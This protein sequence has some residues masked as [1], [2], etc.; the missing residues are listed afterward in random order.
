M[1]SF[2]LALSL[3]A[4]TTDLSTSRQAAGPGTG[5][6]CP[7]IGC[8]SNTSKV[9][10]IP[11]IRAHE[12]GRPNS[13]GF[14]IVRFE[15]PLAA[16]GWKRYHADVVDA[17]LLVRD[18]RTNVIVFSGVHVTGG[19]FVLA[20][21]TTGLEYYLEV[22]A[23]GTQE[24]WA[25]DDPAH[26]VST[27][28]YHL[29]WEVT[30]ATNSEQNLCDANPDGASGG[31]PPMLD[32][33]AVLFDEE[34]VDVDGLRFTG[35]AHDWFNIGCA[36]NALAKVHF[37]GKTHAASNLLG[38]T[39]TVAERTAHLKMMTADYCGSGNAFTVPGVPL[40]WR[41]SHGWVDTIASG[42]T[43]EARWFEGGALCLNEPRIEYQGAMVPLGSTVFPAGIEILLDDPTWCASR[44][45]PCS[46]DH[47]SMGGADVI[48]ANP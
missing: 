41:D 23:V 48:T 10:G 29:R 37:L 11:F 13:D 1:R 35:T 3:T 21:S 15:M 30:T 6:S 16:G 8:G 18:L 7:N 43:L 9:D 17:Q 4:C 44:P 12:G 28:I 20:S 27:F 24:L 32:F 40:A 34:L 45:P 46:G 33:M 31:G 25:Q 42:A 22:H 36:G 14:S 19:R 39:T 47:T 5:G 26:P 2:V 38:V